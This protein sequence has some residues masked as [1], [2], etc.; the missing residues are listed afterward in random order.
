M[1]SLSYLVI[2][3]IKKIIALAIALILLGLIAAGA[4]SIAGGFGVLTVIA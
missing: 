1:A 2:K 4:L 3:Y